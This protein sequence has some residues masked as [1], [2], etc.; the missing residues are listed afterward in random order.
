MTSLERVTAPAVEALTLADFKASQARIDGTADDAA[1]Q[2][3]VNAAI[4]YVDGDGALGRALITQTWAQWGPNTGQDVTLVMGPFQSLTS[5][6][7]Y[8]TEGTLQTAT[9]SDFEV[10]RRGD[11][12]I[13]RPKKGA[14]WPAADDRE[15][16]VKITYVAGFGNA[17]TD[18]PP[19][20]LQA[21]RLVA[22]HFYE[23]R[24]ATTDLRLAPL[25]LGVEDLLSVYRVGWVGG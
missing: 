14:S 15:D 8:D 11:Y 18:I 3:A 24:E 9:L 13:C 25:P 20:I 4:S 19:G 1:A 21:V 16:A 6:E 17:A 22:A 2:A 5:V 12:R 7:F 23:N 10:H